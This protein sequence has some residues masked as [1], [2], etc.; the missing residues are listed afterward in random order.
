MRSLTSYC[1]P[2]LVTRPILRSYRT[3]NRPFRLPIFELRVLEYFSEKSQLLVFCSS[4]N[5]KNSGLIG[6]SEN[7]LLFSLFFSFLLFF[8]FLHLFLSSLSPWSCSAGTNQNR[9]SM[10]VFPAALRRPYPAT[11]SSGGGGGDD[12]ALF[13][14]LSLGSTSLSLLGSDLKHSSKGVWGDLF[15]GVGDGGRCHGGWG[16]LRWRMATVDGPQGSRQPSFSLFL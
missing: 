16:L 4:R 13:F 9:G 7:A 5:S 8:L 2:R 10:G 12:A 11:M 1:F 14:L 6:I 15:G 3:R